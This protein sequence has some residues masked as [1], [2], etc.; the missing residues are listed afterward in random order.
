MAEQRFRRST[1]MHGFPS[2]ATGAIMYKLMSPLLR[3]ALFAAAALAA[4]AVV[5]APD[6]EQWLQD[7]EAAYDGVGTYTAIFH[8]QQ[9]VAGI[10]Q[11][12]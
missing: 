9:R 4:H 11:P 5:A 6:A 2:T 1:M 8:K 3:S 7:A 10:L 12:A